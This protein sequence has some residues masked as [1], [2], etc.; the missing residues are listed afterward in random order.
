MARSGDEGFDQR[1]DRWVEAGRQFVDGVSGARPGSRGGARSSSR[2]GNTRLNPG[3]L[4]RWV[5][6]KLEWLLEDEGGDDWREPWQT[7]PPQVQPQDQP[8]VQPQSRSRRR[9][10]EAISRRGRRTDVSADGRADDAWPDDESFS[11]PRWQ[12]QATRT[13]A[14]PLEGRAGEAPRGRLNGERPLPRST[15]RR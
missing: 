1:L 10:L 15:R 4:G 5:E 3:E 12:R 11:V 13:P 8:R 14:D 6:N 9:P 7:T 2:R